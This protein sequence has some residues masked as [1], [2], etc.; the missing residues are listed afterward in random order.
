MKKINVGSIMKSVG[1]TRK[2]D[3]LGRI[4]IPKEFR[5]TIGVKEKEELQITL[6]SNNE[7]VLKKCSTT[8]DYESIIRSY[9]RSELG[10]EYW[11]TLITKDNIRRFKELIA[12][13]I[14]EVVIKNSK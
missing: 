2:I 4:V 11:D 1:L 6:N 9:I 14:N 3:E 12:D 8:L 10:N 13:F 5:N 7:L